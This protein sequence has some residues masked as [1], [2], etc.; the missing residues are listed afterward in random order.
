MAKIC[1]LLLASCCVA[2]QAETINFDD[3]A[4]GAP[5]AG[6]LTT[7]T[8]KGQ[9]NWTVIADPT[10]PS[11]PNVLRQ[12]GVATFPLCIKEQ[13]SLKDGFVEVEFKPVSGKEDQ[14]GGVVWRCLDNA[15]YYV[16]R[17]NALENNLTIYHTLKG[18]R[19]AFKNV[20]VPVA[21][22]AWHTLRV[23][24]TGNRFAVSLDGRKLID[25]TDDSLAGPGKVGLWTKSDS[26]TLFDDFSF[27]S[28]AH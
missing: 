18:R 8:G 10:A 4:P 22:Q 5:P 28:I 3:L 14:A 2:A 13:T 26:L 25:A 16:A 17:A 19:V 23:E 9:A 6:W 24:F 1:F 7:V 20:N 11:K 15:N 21:A 27:G 12:S